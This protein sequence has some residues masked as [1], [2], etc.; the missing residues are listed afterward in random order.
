MKAAVIRKAGGRVE[1]EDRGRP[2]PGPDEVLIRVHACGVCH[3]DLMVR[4]GQF[5]FARYPIVPGH[6]IAETVEATGERVD[7][8]GAFGEMDK[9]HMRG[10]AVVVMH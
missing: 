3:G 1:L 9:G 7:P 4:D 8:A 6:E 10:R 5:P 2:T